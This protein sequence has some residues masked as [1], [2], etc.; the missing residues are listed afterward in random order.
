MQLG[1]PGITT[2]LN[3]RKK[4]T[5]PLPRTRESEISLRSLPATPAN[6]LAKLGR[7]KGRRHG[8]TSDD[9][10][11]GDDTNG[12]YALAQ[13]LVSRTFEGRIDL[14]MLKQ[15]KSTF[16]KA[17]TDGGGTLDEQ[18]FIN[19]FGSILGGRMTEDQ[20]RLWFMRIDAN[21]NGSVD[22]DEFSSYLLLEAQKEQTQSEVQQQDY[23]F[24]GPPPGDLEYAH[25]DMVTALLVHPR[26]GKCY[27]T[28]RDGV[29]KMWNA[30]TLNWE[31]N[32]Q[33]T[34]VWITDA[35]WMRNHTKIVTASI[36][37]RVC[38][39]EA[40]NGDVMRCYIGHKHTSQKRDKLCLNASGNRQKSSEANLDVGL[41]TVKSCIGTSFND[42][43]HSL[44]KLKSER[45]E[46]VTIDVTC[47]LGLTDSPMSIEYYAAEPESDTP[48]SEYILLGLRNGV[49][50][51]YSL[52]TPIGAPVPPTFSNH[53]H[54]STISK[55]KYSAFLGGLITS[56]WDTSLK[57]TNLETSQVLRTLGGPTSHS[58]HSKSVFSFDWSEDAKL[59]ASCGAERTVFLWNP[60]ISQPIL[61][62][63]GHQ[64][65]LVTACFYESYYL[66]TLSAD[67]MV[68][69]WDLRTFQAVNTLVNHS[70]YR[71][72]NTLTCLYYDQPRQRFC[73]AS[74]FPV[75]W[76]LKK[77]VTLF[78]AH[79]TG[80]TKP[81]IRALYNANFN[82]VVSTDGETVMVWDP[83]TG[84]RVFS[85][86][87]R[88]IIGEDTITTMRFDGAQRRIITGTHLGKLHFWN[89]I[90]GQCLKELTA[91]NKCEI[92]GTVHILHE[93]QDLRQVFA[94]AGPT[95]Y[96]WAETEGKSDTPLSTFCHQ[97]ASICAIA[98]CGT[99]VIAC[100]VDG[101]VIVLYSMLTGSETGVLGTARPTVTIEE[102]AFLPSRDGLL[103]V[104][105]SDGHV[106]LWY[107]TERKLLCSLDDS[108]GSD[109]SVCC[110][111]TN[112]NN[113]LLATGDDC[114]YVSIWDISRLVPKAGFHKDTVAR[115]KRFRAHEVAVA[116][117][118]FL[119]RTEATY[120][121]TAAKDCSVKLYTTKG[122]YVGAFGDASVWAIG[123][124]RSYA[125]PTLPFQ[126]EDTA[127]AKASS[128]QFLSDNYRPTTKEPATPSSQMPEV[129][130]ASPNAPRPPKFDPTS[131]TLAVPTT[132]KHFKRRGAGKR[133]IVK[134]DW[135]RPQ[136]HG[137]GS[138][139]SSDLIS[140]EEMPEGT[141]GSSIESLPVTPRV[142][143][144]PAPRESLTPRLPLVAK[145]PSLASLH[146][147]IVQLR[148][149]QSGIP[150]DRLP[151][152]ESDFTNDSSM[153]W[154]FLSS[155]SER[156]SERRAHATPRTRQQQGNWLT[157]VSSRLPVITPRDDIVAP[158]FIPPKTDVLVQLRCD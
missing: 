154:Q 99:S 116:S 61:T 140:H 81:V 20:L 76:A 102:M 72:E 88:S 78:P 51:M 14:K 25:S 71:P 119:D 27:T 16:E 15:L 91:T 120:I 138:T 82:Q 67:K 30:N 11:S 41:R 4:S 52:N 157:R 24:S 40:G 89:Y 115:V 141:Q 147:R 95:L 131:N 151:L 10:G 48:T 103:A 33:A 113:S 69:L 156:L 47:L 53:L 13:Q 34:G 43:Q 132:G 117:L 109:R 36:D 80:H 136:T 54:L 135:S 126:A 2:K 75:V 6:E 148:S 39:Y 74:A 124:P 37:R 60:F 98:H 22:W 66:A 123:M 150:V 129:V 149:L 97:G 3:N 134:R 44:R 94:A 152:N 17:D 101:G 73:S 153:E 31:K 29:V 90:T 112:S 9:E 77:Q 139:A 137:A 23:I 84:E 62:L 106:Q 65:P 92:T 18:E 55:V 8:K 21:A 108:Q 107:L 35:C 93:V 142:Q 122:Q 38:I 87:T 100:A 143:P 57:L 26:N 63:D 79:Y 110:L 128:I 1:V 130:L 68:K 56:S 144:D 83:D 158:A 58:G 12:N 111:A 118:S 105:R 28:A 104:A 146:E 49:L 114:G 46:N 19:A 96:L 145:Q 64:A 133:D 50:Q 86:S 70:A 121:I 5:A 7:P 85:F 45:N 32:I 155:V 125:P 127:V 59:I 42:F